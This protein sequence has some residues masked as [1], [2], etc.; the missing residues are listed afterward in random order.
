MP[1]KDKKTPDK[2]KLAN[3]KKPERPK[4]K[5]EY[6]MRTRLEETMRY[7]RQIQEAHGK[8]RDWRWWE[9][10]DGT[11]SEILVKLRAAFAMGCPDLEACIYAGISETQLYYY[12]KNVNKDFAREKKFLKDVPILR[13]RNTI[14]ENV[15]EVENAKWYLKMK[16]R[17]EF[18][19]KVFFTGTI[20][21]GRIPDDRVQE[22]DKILQENG[23]NLIEQQPEE[24]FEE[25]EVDYDEKNTIM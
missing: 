13:A 1:K 10:E 4:K 5:K 2:A 24:N 20:I 14:V 16:K 8:P 12:Q 6:K 22:I 11:D 25:N 7:I 21:A 3:I 19:E 9:K 18:S 23:L 15:D 17:D